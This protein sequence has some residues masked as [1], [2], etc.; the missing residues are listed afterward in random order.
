MEENSIE[1]TENSQSDVD[2][3]MKERMLL[4][5]MKLEVKP[6]Y[7]DDKKCIDEGLEKIVI[8]V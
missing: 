7:K 3:N 6:K 2:Y 5:T 1:L 4:V 8:L